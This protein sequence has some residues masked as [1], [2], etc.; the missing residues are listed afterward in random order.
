MCKRLHYYTKNPA[1]LGW[2]SR[3]KRGVP[4]EHRLLALAPTAPIFLGCHAGCAVKRSRKAGLRGELRIE[5]Y[6]GERQF[7]RCQ[8]RHRVLQPPVAYIA[9]RRDPHSECELACKMKHAVTRDFSEIYKRDVVPDVCRDIVENAAEPNM[10][11]TMGGVEG[12]ACPAIAI[13]LEESG[14]KR[15][16]G[17]FDVHAACGRLD[18]ELGED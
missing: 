9:T 8:F 13:L 1:P 16:R 15:Q 10:I 7:A 12:R 18:V 5:R 11:E 2:E 4:R 6:L 3:R 14:R 17:C